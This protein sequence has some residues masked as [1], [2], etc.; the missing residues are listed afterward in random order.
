MT[1]RDNIVIKALCGTR[2]DDYSAIA[3]KVMEH[4]PLAMKEPSLFLNI[5]DSGVNNGASFFFD[6]VHEAR[7]FAKRML[8]Q[9]DLY[10][11][12]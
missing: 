3:L 12:A 8:E 9:L 1:D 2:I 11:P 10:L 7:T 6:N 4:G 5:E